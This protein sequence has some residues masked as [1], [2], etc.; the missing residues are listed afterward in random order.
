[1]VLTP[2]TQTLSHPTASRARGVPALTTQHPLNHPTLQPHIQP[3][4]PPS[5][6]ASLL[7]AYTWSLGNLKQRQMGPLVTTT[8]SHAFVVKQPLLLS[9][10]FALS[11]SAFALYILM[12]RNL[13][14]HVE[15]D[16]I[17]VDPQQLSDITSNQF[18]SNQLLGNEP[19]LLS[20]NGLYWRRQIGPSQKL[21]HLPRNAIC[22]RFACI[23]WWSAAVYHLSP[24]TCFHTLY[25]KSCQSS[26]FYPISSSLF[27]VFC[28]QS[29]RLSS[30]SCSYQEPFSLMWLTKQVACLSNSSLLYIRASHLLGGDNR[31]RRSC[32][33]TRNIWIL[34]SGCFVK[35]RVGITCVEIIRLAAVQCNKGIGCHLRH[36]PLLLVCIIKAFNCFKNLVNQSVCAWKCKI[37]SIPWQ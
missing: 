14:W 31:G 1:M 21:S 36:A 19:R 23:F 20:T 30:S 37:K 24:R 10:S 12:Y 3:P 11:A 26:P 35:N 33:I 9:L 2:L 27:A 25:E 17:P 29:K 13:A 34:P 5:L 8:A 18:G 22:H 28:S 4:C 15:V 16:S 32:H 7:S 6:N